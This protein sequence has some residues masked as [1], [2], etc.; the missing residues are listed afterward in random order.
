MRRLAK[1]LAVVLALISPVMLLWQA[2]SAAASGERWIIDSD[3][4]IDDWV[5]MLYLSNERGED[6]VALTATGNGLARCESARRNAVRILQLD[7]TRVPVGCS[8]RAP[9][10]G[11]NAY[12]T[13]WR[14]QSD[15]LIGLEVPM[16]KRP[17]RLSSTALM[18]KV[19]R[20]AKEPMSILSLG[21]M[22][23][24]A[25]V[26]TQS[27]HLKKKIRRIVAMA[28]AVDVPGNIRVH[29]FTDD[30][31]N[32]VAEWNL[33]IDPVAAKIV[34][35]SDVPLE[36]VPLDATNRAPLTDAFIQRFEQMTSGAD[37]TFVSRVFT[38]VTSSNDAGEYYH[39]DPL[40]A[41]IAIDPRIC[42]RREL[43]RLTVVAD[44]AGPS[45][46]PQFPDRNWLGEPRHELVEATAGALTSAGA[47]RDITVCLRPD[48]SRFE[49]R[50]IDA[51]RRV[52]R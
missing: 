4:G 14:D 38:Q 21:T 25:E 30:S 7:D 5:S 52:D 19:L 40:A 32:T 2:P 28:G 37:A 46:D 34:L 48:V 47:K 39:W 11:T 50:M 6:I 16:A 29:G 45:T 33:F 26:I 24:I 9:L 51:F 10:D 43:R 22:R 23:T 15:Q 8:H 3:M 18:K 13:Q 31:P 17:P 44:V 1:V 12:P 27:P 36:I 35:D 42:E 49:E 20:E 41:A